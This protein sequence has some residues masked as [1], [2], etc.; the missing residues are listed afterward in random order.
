MKKPKAW[1]QNGLFDVFDKRIPGEIE[2]SGIRTVLRLH[3]RG[4]ERGASH[5]RYYALATL[6]DR[7]VTGTLNDNSKVSLLNCALTR[8]G[9]GPL[10]Q[11]PYWFAELRPVFVVH[12][13][14]YVTPK[15]EIVSAI[16]LT[17]DDAHTIFYDFE[18]FAHLLDPERYIRDLATAQSDAVGRLRGENPIAIEVGPNPVIQYFTGKTQIMRAETAIGEVSAT[19]I[20]RT[21]WAVLA[22]SR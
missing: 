11:D 21:H 15:D 19:T 3:E 16:H 6:P 17:P 12:G 5:A 18:A 2:V 8:S 10:N 20:Q 7:C 4:T 22:A 9:E 13:E 14:T 1:R